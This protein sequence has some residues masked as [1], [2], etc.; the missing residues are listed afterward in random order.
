M[1]ADQR[2]AIKIRKQIIFVDVTIDERMSNQAS[3]PKVNFYFFFF[4]DFCEFSGSVCRLDLRTICE[5][6][7]IFEFLKV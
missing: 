2:K 6:L 4:K 7:K 5:F 1:K 3:F